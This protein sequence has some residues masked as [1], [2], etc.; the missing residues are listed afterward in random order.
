MPAFRSTLYFVLIFLLGA[1]S[2]SRDLSSHYQSAIDAPTSGATTLV[3]L[4]D[5][6]PVRTLKT[7]FSAGQLPHLQSFFLGDKKEFYQARPVLPSLT[8]PNLIS[9]ITEKSVDQ[10]HIY[11]N[12]VF[13]GGQFFDFESPSTHRFLNKHIEG[14]SIFSRLKKKGLR[15]VA[16]GYNF[17]ADTTSH[18]HPAD[19]EAAVHILDKEYLSVD[20]KLIASL[21]LLLDE[22][23]PEKWPDFIFMHLIGLDFTSHDLGP[24]S[25]EAHLYLRKLDLMLGD[26]FLKLEKAE[27]QK[28]RKV[29]ALLTSDHGFSLPVREIIDL[30]TELPSNSRVAI[31]NEGRMASLIFPVGWNSD[32]KRSYFNRVAT[33][34]GIALKAAR[35][36][37]E[38]IIEPAGAHPELRESLIQYFQNPD[39]PGMLIMAESGFGFTD[40]YK[41]FHGGPST[42][43]MTIPL[44]LRNG[45][46]R[47]PS[48]LPYIH[49]LLQFIAEK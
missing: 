3:L 18:T 48:R 15:T 27:I 21:Q 13:I 33:Q 23:S 38:I 2:T 4:I 25:P 37:T 41:G 5:G 7:L 31:Q 47:D 49:E 1:C 22:T 26:L 39:H 28:R 19:I 16:V 42:E 32:Q 30:K 10:H 9:L 36:G 6:L 12:K 34:N 29:V 8:Y 45:R 17:W 14:K 35:V 46:L 43:E 40:D 24:D 44:L 11:G 20:S